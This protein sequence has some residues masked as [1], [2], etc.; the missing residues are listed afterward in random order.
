MKPRRSEQEPAVPEAARPSSIEQHG[1]WPEVRGFLGLEPGDNGVLAKCLRD[2]ARVEQEGREAGSGPDL[3][4]EINRLQ[5]EVREWQRKTTPCPACRAPINPDLIRQRDEAEDKLAAKRGELQSRDARLAEIGKRQR[6]A[7]ARAVAALHGCLRHRL[8]RLAHEAM[9]IVN[10]APPAA[11][12][13]PARLPD[14]LLEVE[15]QVNLGQALGLA[16]SSTAVG[17]SAAE[18][19]FWSALPEDVRALVEAKFLA[20]RSATVAA[21]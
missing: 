7:H 14:L 21:S 8:E 9:L 11:Q 19:D 4:R 15:R 1:R 5:F 20:G 12:A 6:E 17:E 2:L 3:Q 13:Y 10:T 16:F 18:I